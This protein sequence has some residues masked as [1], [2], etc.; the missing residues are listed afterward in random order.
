LQSV[1]CSDH[2]LLV[3]ATSGGHPS[4]RERAILEEGIFG[5][6]LHIRPQKATSTP[7]IRRQSDRFLRPEESPSIVVWIVLT[8]EA[9]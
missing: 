9:V 7:G 1:E 6:Y 2:L 3:Q 8:I 5:P 4:W